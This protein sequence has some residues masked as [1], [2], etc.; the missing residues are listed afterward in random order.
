MNVSPLWQVKQL[1]YS[2]QNNINGIFFSLSLNYI[3]SLTPQF[4]G[5]FFFLFLILL[6]HIA[7]NVC[8][9]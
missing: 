4:L 3:G 9:M 8:E 7:T 2:F 5:F 6:E 1:N